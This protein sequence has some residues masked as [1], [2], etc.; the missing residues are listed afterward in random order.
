MLAAFAEIAEIERETIVQRVRSGLDAAKKR[1]TKLGAP[2][3][4]SR[5][6]QVEA[7]ALKAEGLSFKKIALRLDLSVGSV[8]ALVMGGDLGE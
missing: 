5:D 6:K 7:R 8:H 4:V 2:A 1:G 3:K